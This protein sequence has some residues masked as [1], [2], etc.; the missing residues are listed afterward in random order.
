[1]NKIIF[2]L[3][4]G[5]F[6]FI[7]CGIVMAENNQTDQA[8]SSGS[9]YWLSEKEIADLSHN[10]HYGDKDA[11]FRLY[12]YHLLVSLNTEQEYKWL[13]QS[14]KNGHQTAQSHLAER[15]LEENN[16]EKAIF[17][18]KKAHDNGAKLTDNLLD[19]INKKP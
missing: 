10:A 19:L 18:A 2:S 13:L 16:K 14:A 9:I 15:F 6:L 1:M 12:Q 3:L 5:T 17:W 7:S 11:A 4:A 8:V